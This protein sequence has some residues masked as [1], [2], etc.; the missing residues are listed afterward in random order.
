[1]YFRNYGLRKT[2]LK[3]CLINTVSED[4]SASGMVNGYKH[5]W[6]LADTTFSIVIDHYE[7]SWLEKNLSY[8]DEKT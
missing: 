3:K 5:C 7:G 4:T 1:M 2:L 6:N 8:I